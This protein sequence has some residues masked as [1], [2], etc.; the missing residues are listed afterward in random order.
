MSFDRLAPH[1]PWLEKLL[2]G[3]R[4]QRCRVAHLDALR[5]SDRVLIAGIGHG[6]FLPACAR[7]V[8]HGAIT[9]VDASAAMLTETRRLA[10]RAGLDFNRLDFVHATLPAWEPPAAQFDV[11]VTNFFLDCFAPDELPAII[12]ALARAA[13]PDARWLLADFTVPARGF[14]RQRAR[15]I[16]AA[17]YAFF[18]PATGLRARRVTAPDALLA[19]HGF[20]L[21]RRRP[22]EWGLLH[23]D[24]WA[25]P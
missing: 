5:D 25:R 12:A 3:P 21:R 2:A 16:H 19:A 9:C 23:A 15:A 11:I 4:L 1:Y 7:R 18:R 22:S 8:P 13:R 10:R 14:A 24:L 6:P 20:H 17:M